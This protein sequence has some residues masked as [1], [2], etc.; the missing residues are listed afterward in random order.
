MPY[1]FPTDIILAGKLQQICE[2]PCLSNS[3]GVVQVLRVVFDIY[4]FSAPKN[5]PPVLHDRCQRASYEVVVGKSLKLGANNHQ[6][7]AKALN[8]SNSLCA[9]D[10][11]S[12]DP[13]TGHKQPSNMKFGPT[14]VQEQ[15]TKNRQK[16]NQNRWVKI[17]FAEKDLRKDPGDFRQLFTHIAHFDDWNQ[18]EIDNSSYAITTNDYIPINEA[19]LHLNAQL[20]RNN[21]RN[22]SYQSLRRKLI[23]W[24]K[25]GDF[26]NLVT[27][28]DGGHTRVHFRLLLKILNREVFNKRRAH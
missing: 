26:K 20:V 14:A 1:D 12:L 21:N 4:F 24:D 13:R 3:P 7:L 5:K 2:W 22:W 10:W 27:K 19:A 28:T 9:L 25:A 17:K 11:L 23:S 8:I 16:S 15:D 18:H 6:A